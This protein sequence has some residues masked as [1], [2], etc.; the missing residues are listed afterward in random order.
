MTTDIRSLSLLFITHDLQVE[1]RV[2][3]FPPLIQVFAV[4]LRVEFG[5]CLHGAAFVSTAVFISLYPYIFRLYKL[6][7]YSYSL[8]YFCILAYIPTSPCIPVYP[9]P[10]DAEPLNCRHCGR[11]VMQ[12]LV[13]QGFG[14]GTAYT[15]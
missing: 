14:L 1:F 10:H 12:E 6:C 7:P 13:P 11:T 8:T 4:Q 5:C 2:V 9:L 15:P 3:S